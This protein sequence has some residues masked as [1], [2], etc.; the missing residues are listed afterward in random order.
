GQLEQRQL[1]SHR[2]GRLEI[3]DLQD[4]DQLVQLLRDLIDR[5]QRTVQRQRDPRQVLVVRRP[6]GE[7]VDVE[8]AAGEQARDPG[9]DTRLVLHQNRQD[10][11]APRVHAAGSLEL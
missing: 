1:P 10:V 2:V 8:P 11:L 9:Q 4:V 7:R 6:D 5:V 3:A